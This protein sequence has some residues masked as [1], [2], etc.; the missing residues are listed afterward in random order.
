MCRENVAPVAFGLAL[1]LILAGIVHGDITTGLVGYWPLDGDGT[2][3]S[4]NGLH[5]TV[6]GNVIP[7]PDRSGYA[8]AALSFPGDAG[9]YIGVA[10]SPEL[11]ITGE[12][13]LAAWVFLNSTNQNNAR[14][15]AKGGGSGRRSWNLN[16]EESSGGVANPA[17][18]QVSATGATSLSV[19]DTRPLPTDKWVHMAGIYRPGEAMEVYVDGAL[20]TRN[21]TDIPAAQFSDNGLAMF[22]G[23]RNACGDCGWNGFIDE[24]RVYRRALSPDDIKE[25]VAFH[26]A[27]RV[28]AWSPEPADGAT[29]IV[30]PLFRWKPGVT[31]ALH[32]IYVGTNPELGAGELAGFHLPITTH[33]YGPGLVPGVTY[34]W[35]VD[36]IEVDMTT[37]HT[38]DVWQFTAAPVI[39]YDPRPYDG[40]RWV[41]A[42]VDLNWTGG[43]NAIAHEVYFGTDEAAVA[44]GTG[45]TFRVK[46]PAITFDPGTL[47]AGT[48]YYWRVDE[49]ST[50]GTEKGQVWSF[51]TIGPGGGAKGE[52]F[53]NMDLSGDPA[54][55]RIDEAIDFS[56]PD[57]STAGTNSPAEGIPTNGFSGRWTADLE[58]DRAG[59]Y[60][61][62]TRSDDGVRL[63]LDGVRVINNWTDHA[64]TDNLSDP[65]ELVP[66][67]VYALVMET[68]ENTGGAAARLSWESSSLARQVIPRGPLQPPAHAGMPS[69]A[70][71]AA[72]VPQ[73]VVLSWWAGDEAS[74]HDVYFGEDADAVVSADTSSAAYQGRQMLDATTFDAGTLAWGKTCYWRIDEVNGRTVKGSVWS[75]TTADCLVV[76]NFESYND[77]VEAHTTIYDTWIDGLV[78]NTGAL[79]GYWDAPFAEQTMVHGDNQSMPLDYNN[80]NP[81]YYSEAE[82]TWE[83]PQNWTIN[84]VDTLT[85]YV[86]GQASNAPDRLYVAVQ[87]STNHLGVAAYP[88]SAILTATK[89]TEWKIP[90]SEFS[91]V[92]PAK[93]ETIYIGVGDR[94]NPTPGG[95][96]LIYIDDIRVVRPAPAVE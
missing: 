79:V 82:R 52:Y 9:S 94:D 70:H 93:I 21:T 57:G 4:G 50:A 53:T 23:S 61:F 96:G 6:N 67:R 32:D 37:V 19:L 85:L 95:A 29:G 72:Y 27:P 25:L 45:D 80:V 17:T 64:P 34:Y 62:V 16:I 84:G 49:V 76:D 60:T 59:S 69:P 81:P 75:F 33:W 22:I 12:I 44:E 89:W 43:L 20:R 3:L 11:N 5:G 51:T 14:I 24:A 65:V 68:Y 39:A 56:W 46:Q 92:N 35:R 42:D 8:D 13:T 55:T 91:G 30:T 66:G 18:F 78:N 74:H 36:E 2:D 41:D 7:A 63:Y 38:G 26:P 77:D 86:R 47:Q 71:G 90:L 83:T 15:I 28:K 54:V 40:A 88:D 48:T 1:S 10:D 58:V 31:A 73:D 87:D